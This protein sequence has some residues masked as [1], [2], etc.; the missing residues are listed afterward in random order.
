MSLMQH[1]QQG[2]HLS[3]GF[4]STACKH[5][6]GQAL[7]DHSAEETPCGRYTMN[8]AAQVCS[9]MRMD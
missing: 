3:N 7:S 5:V 1:Q 8:A 2:G 6:V 9:I 4:A